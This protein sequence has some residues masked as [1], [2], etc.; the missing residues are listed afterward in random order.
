MRI[1]ARTIVSVLPAILFFASTASAQNWVANGNFDSNVGSWIIEDAGASIV[2]DAAF[3]NPAPGSMRITNSVPN[4]NTAAGVVQCLGEVTVGKQYSWGGRM[5][6][7]SG[8]NRTGRAM[9]GLRWRTGP[10]C[11]GTSL[12]Q[13][14]L[15]TTLLDTWDLKT[16]NDA[17]P[18]GAVSV[19]YVFFPSKVEAGGSLIAYFDNIFFKQADGLV[20]PC[21]ADGITLCLNGNRFALTATWRTA[22][23][24]GAGTAVPL[25]GDTGAFWFFSSNNLEGI[26]KL[27]TGCPVNNSYWFFGGGLTNVEVIL[28]AFDTATGTA[29]VYLNPLNTA[30]QPIQDTSVFKC[31]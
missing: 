8:Q 3:G 31:P 24:A 18:P 19:Q 20:P 23:A 11:T 14:R 22:N 5:F 29:A 6:I 26:F 15:Q 28:R 25:T 1:S 4:Q 13:P 7:P 21:V 27:V 12:D 2:F 16:E 30:F 17:A 9:L 10:G